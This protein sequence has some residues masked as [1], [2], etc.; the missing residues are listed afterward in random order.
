MMMTPVV[1]VRARFESAVLKLRGLPA[2]P[3]RHSEAT[4]LSHTMPIARHTLRQAYWAVAKEV[5]PDRLSTPLATDA[6][7][8]LNEAYRQA[9]LQFSVREPDV[10]RLDALGL[11]HDGHAIV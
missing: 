1:C 9:V 4:L 5:H 3:C 8:V 7:T 10:I 2:Q 11:E 6:M